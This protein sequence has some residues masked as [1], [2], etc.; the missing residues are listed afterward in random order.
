M[1]ADNDIPLRIAAFCAIDFSRGVVNKFIS[2][3]CL[4]ILNC[5][6]F[7]LPVNYHFTIKLI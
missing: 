1:Y 5:F 6:S 7:M 4:S 3:V 2:T